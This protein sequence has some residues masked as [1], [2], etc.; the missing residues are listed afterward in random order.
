MD[1][2]LQ[3]ASTAAARIL[4]QLLLVCLD[5]TLDSEDLFCW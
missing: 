2:Q 1:I 4:L 5:F 3:Y